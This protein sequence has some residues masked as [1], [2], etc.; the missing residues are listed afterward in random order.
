V[1][2]RNQGDGHSLHIMT[3]LWP[4]PH[5]GTESLASTH[6][7]DAACTG[8]SALRALL[9]RISAC[10]GR[11]WMP[12]AIPVQSRRRSL[13]LPAAVVR[14]TIILP[15][16]SPPGQ[17]SVAVTQDQSGN[18]VVA[19]RSA[20]PIRV[21]DCDG[22]YSYFARDLRHRLRSVERDRRSSGGDHLHPTRL[23]R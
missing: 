12:G 20:P 8:S 10:R 23:R 9:C 2:S 15:R 22:A 5:A 11:Q 16:F 18:G 19:Q 17:Y 3:V 21:D 14:V 4:I 1:H 7:H 13:L 6:P